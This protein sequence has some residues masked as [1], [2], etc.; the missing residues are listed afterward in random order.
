LKTKFK[1]FKNINA[2]KKYREQ[3]NYYSPLIIEKKSLEKIKMVYNNQYIIEIGQCADNLVGILYS[4]NSVNELRTIPTKS[5]QIIIPQFNSF[6]DYVSELI[7]NGTKDSINVSNDKNTD[8]ESKE[9]SVC[10][11]IPN[12]II[13]DMQYIDEAMQG[14][15]KIMNSVTYMDWLYNAIN[16]IEVIYYY[17]LLVLIINL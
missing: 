14:L 8:D 17:F 2:I 15:E 5:T 16:Q 3:I 11:K 10:L 9:D 6:V 12:G 13:F 1:L 7:I 4:D